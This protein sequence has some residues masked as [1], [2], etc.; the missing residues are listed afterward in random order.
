MGATVQHDLEGE[1]VGPVVEHETSMTKTHVFTTA[2]FS[3]RLKEA[4]VLEARGATEAGRRG[5]VQKKMRPQS[6][7]RVIPIGA[8]EFELEAVCVE[9]TTFDLARFG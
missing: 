9:I 7:V 8:F 6:G 4:A 3:V 5:I 1:V 2:H